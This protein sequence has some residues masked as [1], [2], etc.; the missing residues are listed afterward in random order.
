MI[1]ILMATYNGEEYIH[2]QIQSILSQTYTEWILYIRDDKST[3]KTVSIIRK[4]V[5]KYPNK[6]IFIEDDLGSLGA[7]NNFSQLINYS[8]NEYCMFCDQDDVWLE[9]KIEISMD[10][11]KSGEKLHG[12]NKPILVHTDLSVVD[13]KLNLIDNSYWKFQ[14]LNVENKTINRLLVENNITG[15]TILINKILK[16]KIVNIPKNAIMHDWWI[17]LIATIFGN[18]IV[19]SEKTI[20]Y[21]QHTKNEI[22]AKNIKNIKLLISKFKLNEIKLSINRSIDQANEFY[23]MYYRE[24][25]KSDRQVIEDF[26]KIKSNKMINRKLIAIKNKF[27]KHNIIKKI[28]YLIF[29]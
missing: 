10:A 20:L 27:Y 25:N 5:E 8:I 22:G 4:F 19:V 26:I 12:N 1:D 29:I 9:N 13:E 21:R 23:E 7:K 18:I 24:L 11:M 2:E 6:I 16:D 28:V 15:C 14:G 3:D 17:G